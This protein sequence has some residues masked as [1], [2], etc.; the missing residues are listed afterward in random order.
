M[1]KINSITVRIIFLLLFCS[2]II[3]NIFSFEPSLIFDYFGTWCYEV[4]EM[5][6]TISVDKL[7]AFDNRDNTGFTVRIISW[8]FLV[9]DGDN[10]NEYPYGFEI[11]GEIEK[12][13]GSWW[14]GIGEIDS[15][16]WYI[17]IDK[18]SLITDRG[19]IYIKQ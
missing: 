15:W 12:M 14:I 7:V 16:I 4:N 8:E 3:G 13:T 11:T 19:T 6:Y 10:S 9:N 18:D 2:I 17:S 1:K 5:Y